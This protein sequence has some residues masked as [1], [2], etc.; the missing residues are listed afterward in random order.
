MQLH[1]LGEADGSAS[2]H[3]CCCWLTDNARRTTTHL[4]IL[5][6]NIMTAGLQ[7]Q[8]SCGCFSFF[9]SRLAK[10]QNKGRQIF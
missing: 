6:L 9:S 4:V 3:A 2:L 1:L 5:L 8:I 10:R 7:V